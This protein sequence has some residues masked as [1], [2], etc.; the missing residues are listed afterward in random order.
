[1][2]NDAIANI[3]PKSE[4]DDGSLNNFNAKL[5]VYISG[6]FKYR[7]GPRK[8][9]H[10]QINEKIAEVQSTGT[11]SGNIMCQ[12]TP[13]LLHPSIMAASSSSLGMLRMN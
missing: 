8:S 1:M 4:D 7:N 2:D 10:L 13:N 12:N 11:H 9:S 5:A 3:A 6:L